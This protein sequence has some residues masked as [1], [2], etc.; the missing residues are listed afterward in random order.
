MLQDKC[1]GDR[2]KQWRVSA[3]QAEDGR[4]RG[5]VGVHVNVGPLGLWVSPCQPSTPG[6][7]EMAHGFL[8]LVENFISSGAR[9]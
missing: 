7:R 1:L 4:L 8:T 5:N 6:M 9:N 3:A 2:R